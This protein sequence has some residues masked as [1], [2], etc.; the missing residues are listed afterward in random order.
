MSQSG[1]SRLRGVFDRWRPSRRTLSPGRWRLVGTLSA[2]VIAAASWLCGATPKEFSSVWPGVVPWRPNGGSPLACTFIFLALGALA[3]AWWALRDAGLPVRWHV[4]TA[5][6]WFAP[7]L[8]SAPLFSRDIY[9]YAA[10]GL[11]L[12]LGHDPYHEGVR[13]AA[14]TWAGSVSHVWLDSPTPYGPLFLVLAQ[15]CAVVAMGHLLVAIAALRLVAVCGFAV[16]A[17]AVPAIAGR[18]GTDPARAAWLGVLSPLIGTL[19]I[20]GGHNDA[21]MIAGVLA[22]VALALRRHHVLAALACAAATAVKAPAAVVLPFL[23]ILAALDHR[24]TAPLSWI[25]LVLR[26]LAALACSVAAVV[27]ITL[28]TGLGFAW[29]GNLDTSGASI[30]W[31]SLPTGLGMGIGAIGTLFGHNVEYAAVAA[32]RTVAFVVLAVILVG[33]WLHAL[34]HSSDRRLVVLSAGRALLATVILGPAFQG[35]YYLWA[36]P[37]LAATV[38]DRRWRTVLA[39]VASLLTV[40]VL[41]GGYSLALVTAW[42]GVPACFVATVVLARAALRWSRSYPWRELFS[43]SEANAGDAG[44]SPAALRTAGPH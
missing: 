19:L 24:G 30:Q 2:V 6:L 23:A 17:W 44:G 41:P 32:L 22:G 3:Y 18:L 42:V 7:L 20:A 35:W 16:V 26:S 43:L 14:S 21:L 27:G 31:T 28:A 34:R 13:Y 39:A 37:L 40:A 25:R 1:L 5:V 12:H 11:M 29:V 10:D 15:L 36:L 8:L 33:I 4:R 38:T 9:S